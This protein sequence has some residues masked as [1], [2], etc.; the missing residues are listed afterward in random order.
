WRPALPAPRKATRRRAV[1]HT[2]SLMS[3]TRC[4]GASTANA[5][6]ITSAVQSAITAVSTC[7]YLAGLSNHEEIGPIMASTSIV[8]SRLMM[9]KGNS[10]YDPYV[11]LAND[12]AHQNEDPPIKTMKKKNRATLAHKV[13]TLTGEPSQSEH[14]PTE[15]WTPS[16]VG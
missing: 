7:V 14:M 1:N 3:C 2:G 15:I 6:C 16:S 13:K 5:T 4:H 11:P 12:R 9:P 8:K 10:F